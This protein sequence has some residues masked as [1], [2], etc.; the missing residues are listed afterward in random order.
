MAVRKD[1]LH[2]LVEALP[3]AALEPARRFLQW[4]LDEE[5]SIDS[6]P[7]TAAEWDAVRRGEAEIARGEVVRLDDLD[8]H[9]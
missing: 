7:L 4:I 9:V 5:T 8:P 6:L 3:D 1:D 2:R